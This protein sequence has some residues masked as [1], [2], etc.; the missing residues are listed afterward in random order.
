[1][2]GG[3]WG[4][5]GTASILNTTLTEGVPCQSFSFPQVTGAQNVNP[6][7]CFMYRITAQLCTTCE[8]LQCHAFADAGCT[9]ARHPV[10][11]GSLLD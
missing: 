1:V 10:P 9:L 8:N 2:H 4:P 3:A 5:P 11:D 7:V 6:L